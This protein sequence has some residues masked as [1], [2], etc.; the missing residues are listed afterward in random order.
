MADSARVIVQ[1][2]AG[3]IPGTPEEEWTRNFVL[4][5]REW[6]DAGEH[7]A[8]VLAELNGRAQ[9]YASW[10]M[11]QPNRLNWVRTEWMWL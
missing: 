3:V 10:L 1:V 9:G 11:L 5:A 2:M 6:D 4:S 8:E 7:S